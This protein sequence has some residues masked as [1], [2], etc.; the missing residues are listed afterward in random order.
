MKMVSG[1][2]VET[3]SQK[4]S[5]ERKETLEVEGHPDQAM[6]DGEELHGLEGGGRGLA[7]ESTPVELGQD[8]ATSTGHWIERRCP[9][10]LLKL[11]RPGDLQQTI[12]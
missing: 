4:T 6:Q 11:W 10:S 9:T 8:L 5:E 3:R 12:P 2:M 7:S 1:R